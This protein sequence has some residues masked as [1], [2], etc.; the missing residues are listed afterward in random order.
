MREEGVLSDETVQEFTRR[1]DALMETETGLVTASAAMRDF[2]GGEFLPQ[3]LTRIAQNILHR[4]RTGKTRSE[5]PN[6][7]NPA[8]IFAAGEKLAQGQRDLFLRSGSMR[9]SYFS[10]TPDDFAI[11]A[12]DQIALAT[13]RIEGLPHGDY[14]A[15]GPDVRMVRCGTYT[16]HPGDAFVRRDPLVFANPE[17]GR[18]SRYLSYAAARG[19]QAFRLI[20]AKGTLELAGTGCFDIASSKAI[21]FLELFEQLGSE[22]AARVALRYVEHDNPVVRWRAL[23]TL[24]KLRHPATL[25]TLRRFAD[26]EAVFV[27]E[28]ARAI[29]ARSPA[30][31][32]PER[33]VAC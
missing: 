31:G 21:A 19:T 11:V 22:S 4:Q 13:Y 1:L 28:K 12:I 30:Q 17:A 29:L 32:E 3:H 2:V 25:P 6:D 7:D 24:N 23:S 9:S 16:L 26:D 18:K 15:P 14:T 27:R 8:I 5:N 10:A 20:F 33:A